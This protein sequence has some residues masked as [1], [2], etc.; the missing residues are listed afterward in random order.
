MAMKWVSENI[1]AFGG[2]PDNVM[3]FGQSA[4]AASTSLHTLLPQSYQYF[5][6]AGAASGAYTTFS[7]AS[8]A[9]R[10]ELWPMF[11]LDAVAA[12]AGCRVEAN[13]TH[14]IED[15]LV[16]ADT[17]TVMAAAYPANITTYI[18]GTALPTGLTDTIISTF[19]W[20]GGPW[21]PTVD[22]VELK[23]H[24]WKLAASPGHL[25]PG[26]MIIGSNHDEAIMFGNGTPPH[27]PSGCANPP[28]SPSRE[29]FVA[30]RCGSLS[31][32]EHLC[33]AVPADTPVCGSSSGRRSQGRRRSGTTGC[34]RTT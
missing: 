3:I 12:R 5:D 20:V 15:C 17:A 27:L 24:P 10:M 32:P 4:G 30:S 34:S 22:C 31:P 33:Q 2:D 29:H 7:G 19:A 21:S 23:A 11:S 8:W 16:R 6:K 1:I 9:E 26:P 13:K 14:M 18:D 28:P 25:F